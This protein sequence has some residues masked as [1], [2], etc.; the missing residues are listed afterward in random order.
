MVKT[1]LGFSLVAAAG[2]LASHAAHADMADLDGCEKEA[3]NKYDVLRGKD[4]IGQHDIRF[5]MKD[6]ELHVRSETR[7]KVKLLFVTVYRYHYVS[8]EVWR[9]GRLWSVTTRVDDNGKEV[10]TRAVRDGYG[11]AVTDAA[12]VTW[13]TDA[14]FLPT[15]HWNTGAPEFS[16]YLNTIT[17]KLN[18]VT[19]TPATPEEGPEDQML[20]EVRGELN[21][22]TRYHA[23]GYWLGMRFDHKG[24]E[25]EFR[26]TDCDNIAFEES[27]TP[28]AR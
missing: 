4:R 11:F 6:D 18:E 26:C 5:C 20:Y 1:L 3:V 14:D 2:V 8:D 12:G 22:D 17:G 16:T 19:V 24:S 28:A 23:D 7:M 10:L 21:I 27:F 25:I 15:N 9:D 13:R